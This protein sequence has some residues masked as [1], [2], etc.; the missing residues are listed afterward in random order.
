MNNL[1]IVTLLL[2]FNKVV[3]SDVL[4]CGEVSVGSMGLAWTLNGEPYSGVVLCN[5][6]ESEI[7]TIYSNGLKHGVEIR[8]FLNLDPVET[9]KVHYEKGVS[10]QICRE[11]PIGDIPEITCHDV[12]CA[13]ED[14][15]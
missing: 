6:E 15:R 10:Y 13:V 1:K 3:A 12:D 4:E 14:C 8:T 7:R 5:S 9:E 2:I 11:F